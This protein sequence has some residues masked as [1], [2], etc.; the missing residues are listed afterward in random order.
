MLTKLSSKGQLV[1]P[2]NIRQAL[3]LQP[4]AEFNIELVDGCVV[5]QPVVSAARVDE[6]LAKLRLLVADAD[7]LADLEAE[8][9]LELE[10]EYQRER[11]F[12]S[13]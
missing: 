12:Y 7:L 11:H 9:R 8:H 13:G 5:L 4:G 2:R 6:I 1:I 10:Q 3:N